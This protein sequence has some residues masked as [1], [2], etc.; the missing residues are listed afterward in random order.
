M[1]RNIKT[2]FNFDPPVTEHEVQA[3]DLSDELEGGGLNFVLGN[4]RV[5]V[6]EGFDVPAHGVVI[7]NFRRE[8][9]VKRRRRN[10]YLCAS[11]RSKF[12]GGPW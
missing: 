8:G 9:K 5:K 6:E 11:P 3:A 10:L 7:H 4:R 1:C 2:L 12:V